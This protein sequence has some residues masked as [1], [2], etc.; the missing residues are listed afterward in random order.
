MI[1]LQKRGLKTDKLIVERGENRL[2]GV[3]DSISQNEDY[4]DLDR[5]KIRDDVILGHRCSIV[6][7]KSDSSSFFNI[8]TEDTQMVVKL[9]SSHA[10]YDQL[11]GKFD[12]ILT[13]SGDAETIKI[14]VKDAFDTVQYLLASWARMEDESRTPELRKQYRQTRERWGT[15]LEESYANNQ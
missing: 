3:D 13:G 8:A 7:S 15:I 5:E 4:S 14:Q 9:N 1:L 11:F 2:I 6:V 12:S 10:M